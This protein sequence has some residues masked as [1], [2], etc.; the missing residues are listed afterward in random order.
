MGESGGGGVLKA[1]PLAKLGLGHYINPLQLKRHRAEAT[2]NL[3]RR[4][5]VHDLGQI[6]FKHSITLPSKI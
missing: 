1:L 2:Q 5:D 4:Q 6:L 3:Q